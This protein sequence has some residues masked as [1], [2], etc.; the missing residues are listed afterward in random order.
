M[1]VV[2][3]LSPDGVASLGA[4][5]RDAYEIVLPLE[6][7]ESLGA[8]KA[9]LRRRGGER[10]GRSLGALSLA[11]VDAAGN[12]VPIDAATSLLDV[13]EEATSLVCQPTLVSCS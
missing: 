13:K 12:T 11:Y 5:G 2:L 1:P 4:G 3:R 8:L 7:V 10:I 6:R 9:E